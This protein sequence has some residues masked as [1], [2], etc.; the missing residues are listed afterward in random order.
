[1]ITGIIIVFIS[2][3][4]IPKEILECR[5]V[6]REIEFSSCMSVDNFRLAQRVYFRG[7]CIEGDSLFDLNFH[8]HSFCLRVELQVR[9]RDARLNKQ[10]A[11]NH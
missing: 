5:T 1:M 11:A 7:H 3:E 2:V 10:L 6:S 4:R 9:I 8:F